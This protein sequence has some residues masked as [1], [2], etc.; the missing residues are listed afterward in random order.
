MLTLDFTHAFQVFIDRFHDD[1]NLCLV[2][3]HQA[4]LKPIS[5]KALPLPPM[6]YN[7]G[8][9]NNLA[10]LDAV[11]TRDIAFSFPNVDLHN[12]PSETAR[13]GPREAISTA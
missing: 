7:D 8:I 10:F 4:P 3:T 6:T 12:I 13:K 9:C 5:N 1:L 11:C 2:P